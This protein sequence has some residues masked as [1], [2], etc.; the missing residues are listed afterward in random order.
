M[1]LTFEGSSAEIDNII[2]IIRREILKCEINI[3]DCIQR[4]DLNYLKWWQVHKEYLESIV[5]KILVDET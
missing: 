1:K 2:G 4:N 5:G 3:L